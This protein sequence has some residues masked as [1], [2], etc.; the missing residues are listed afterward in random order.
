V[1]IYAFNGISLP[2]DA[3]YFVVVHTLRQETLVE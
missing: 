3:V 2:E 1:E